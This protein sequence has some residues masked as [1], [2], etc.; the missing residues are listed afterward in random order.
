MANSKKL[1]LE[2]TEGGCLVPTS[3]KLNQDG[4]FRKYIVGHGYTM[5]HRYVWQRDNGPI[6]EGYEVDHMCHNR[7]CCE[8]SHLRLLD[9]QV[10]A[11]VSNQDRY[12][13]RLAQAKQFIRDN[14]KVT[15]DAVGKMF[16][17]SFSTGCRWK[18]EVKAECLMPT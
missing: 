6:P 15:G 18:R 2:R 9:G 10:H 16:G 11:V 4:Y 5:Y 7:A 17:V 1:V 12:A 3:H 8:P 14:P 13:D